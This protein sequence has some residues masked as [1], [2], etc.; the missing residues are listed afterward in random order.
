MIP[1]HQFETIK[2]VLNS[3]APFPEELLEGFKSELEFIEFKKDDFLIKEGQ[4][5]NHFYFVVEGVQRVYIET[6]NNFHNI[7][8]TYAPG[9]SG[10]P[11][12]LLSNP[13]SDFNIQCLTPSK[14]YRIPL[15]WFETSLN[16]TLS[17]VEWQCQF[18]KKVLEGRIHREIEMISLDS[19][20][21]Y[22]AFKNRSLNCFDL[23]PKKHLAS[24]LKMT[25]ETF[26]RIHKKYSS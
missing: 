14:L 5:E 6:E 25:L 2:G 7:A 3:L 22:L 13:K 26:S 11:N 10:S 19:E 4:I 18:Y 20:A 24:Y 23:I 16:K 15:K 9:F 12:G 21:R 8:F 1:H 17:F